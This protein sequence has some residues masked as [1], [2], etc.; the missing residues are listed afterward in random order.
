M[1]REVFLCT[2]LLK[3]PG[4]EFGPGTRWLKPC[5]LCY[6]PCIFYFLTLLLLVRGRRCHTYSNLQT[7]DMFSPIPF[8]QTCMVFYKHVSKV[9][10]IS[11][12][13]L[14]SASGFTAAGEE[15]PKQAGHCNQTPGE[16][17]LC[18]RN[19]FSPT[20]VLPALSI[21]LLAMII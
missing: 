9:L 2:S 3:Q 10:V 19:L 11:C 18:R 8:L 21:Q 15:V 16:A 1:H 7:P 20:M 14:C 4:E 17:A 12:W 13:E 6:V 5:Y